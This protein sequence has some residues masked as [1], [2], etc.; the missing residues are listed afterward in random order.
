MATETS[1]KLGVIEAKT[2]A[3]ERFY[4]PGCP[5]VWLTLSMQRRSSVGASPGNLWLLP[6]AFSTRDTVSLL[7]DLMSCFGPS[8]ATRNLGLEP[9]LRPMEC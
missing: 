6:C 7:A 4:F 5:E 1:Q 8:G 2:S 3:Y 9:S